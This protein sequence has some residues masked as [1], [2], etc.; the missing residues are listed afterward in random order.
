MGNFVLGTHGWEKAIEED[1]LEAI[2]RLGEKFTIPLEGTGANPAKIHAEFLDIMQYASQYILLSKM[3][4]RS[5]WWR[6]FHTFNSSDWM[7]ALTLVQLLFS[8]LASCGKLKSC[9]PQS[10]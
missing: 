2:D 6:L 1:Q 3:D 7:N 5:V 4:Y 9:F 10:T 8:L